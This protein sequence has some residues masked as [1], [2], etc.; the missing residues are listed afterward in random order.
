MLDKLREQRDAIQSETSVSVLL[1]VYFPDSSIEAGRLLRRALESVL[2]QR[3]PGEFEIVIVDDGSPTPISSL[4]DVVGPTLASRARWI[5]YERNQ[6]LVYAL[7]TGLREARFPWIA[8]LDADD[9]W[10]SGKIEKQFAL[11]ADDPDL[12]IIGTGMTRVRPDGTVVEQHIRPGSWHGVLQFF[13]DIGCPF[14]HGSVVARRSI[15]RLLGGYPHD[16]TFSHCEDFALWGKWLRFFK[17]AMIEELLYD[18]TVSAESVSN[19]FS[20]QQ[21]QASGLVH[22]AFVRLD[23]VDVIPNALSNLAQAL[24][25]SVM[26]AGVLAYRMWHYRIAAK[27]PVEVVP[28]LRLLMPD[29]NIE[30]VSDK[31]HA[32][33]SLTHVLKDFES[34]A[35]PN[36]AVHTVIVAR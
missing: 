22:G 4:M 3:F 35:L 25:V 29:R 33:L 17:P 2:D 18:Y 23:L 19:R 24:G 31:K 6:G 10:G 11:I 30:L 15:W 9:R 14:P 5:R 34:P 32:A 7:N 16:P 36:R 12:T 21:V 27:L 1:P 13:R 28:M 8:R 26:Q 20:A